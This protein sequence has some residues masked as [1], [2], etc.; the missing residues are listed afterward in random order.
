MPQQPT[1][2]QQRHNTMRGGAGCSSKNRGSK[3]QRPA[4]RS[5]PRG[6]TELSRK[7]HPLVCQPRTTRP[8]SA[9]PWL[10]RLTV[11]FGEGKR[12]SA[13]IPGW[14]GAFTVTST[15]IDV[16]SLSPSLFSVIVRSQ[17][18][19]HPSTFTP[20][21]FSAGVFTATFTCIYVYIHS[22]SPWVHSVLVRSQPH[23]ICIHIHL[24][25][26]L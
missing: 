5:A 1:E 6:R 17:P 12:P 18:H 10:N 20:G 24:R 14:F 23:L 15:Y 4:T 7:K 16:H 8:A 21:A 26:I 2:R 11:T 3:Q 22:H 9:K 25:C 19:L 13:T